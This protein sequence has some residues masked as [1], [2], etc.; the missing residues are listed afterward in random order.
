MKNRTAKFSA[1]LAAGGSGTRFGGEINKVYLPLN[2]QTVIGVCMDKLLSSPLVAELICVYR[3]EDEE[4]LLPVLEEKK[5]KS[6]KRILAVPGGETR[7]ASVYE[8][9][10]Q[11]QEDYVL[12]HDAARPFFTVK[13]ID[14]LAEALKSVSGASVALPSPD[15]VKI[16]NEQGLVLETTDRSRTW[17]VQTPQ[18]FRRSVLLKAHQRVPSSVPVT[19]D[20][21]MLEYCGFDVRLVP[22]SSANQKLTAPEDRALLCGNGQKTETNQ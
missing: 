7:R 6:S 16:T 22:G 11:A 14:D 9:L 21:G 20:C 13:W 12:V 2:G 3:K 19:D 8:G 17:L 4:L 10:K 5:A 15:T 1:I 18:A